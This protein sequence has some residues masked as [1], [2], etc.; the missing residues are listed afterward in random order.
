MS[1]RECVSATNLK[2]KV[3]LRFEWYRTI[4]VYSVIIP[5]H[6]YRSDFSRVFLW[7]KSHHVTLRATRSPLR[8]SSAPPGTE[9]RYHT[10][11]G[12]AGLKSASQCFF[13]VVAKE[14]SAAHKIIPVS[15]NVSVSGVTS[16]P[17]SSRRRSRFAAHSTVAIVMKRESLAR[18]FPTHA[19]LPKP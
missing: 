16:F 1:I 18:C 8:E 12:V 5:G 15:T 19:R 6:A 7:T 9:G 11:T 3:S 4:S 2:A 13:N 10:S 17:F 14:R